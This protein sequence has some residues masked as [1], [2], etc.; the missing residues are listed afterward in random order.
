MKEGDKFYS[1]LLRC[2]LIVKKTGVNDNTP[3]YR[4]S[5]YHWCYGLGLKSTILLEDLKLGSD[6]CLSENFIFTISGLAEGDMFGEVSEINQS[7][8]PMEDKSWLIS[9]YLDSVK[10]NRLYGG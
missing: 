7:G 6:L 4:C 10:L 9:A 1:R 5:L 3:C 2:E 8:L